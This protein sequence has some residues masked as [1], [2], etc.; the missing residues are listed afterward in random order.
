MLLLK[1]VPL[2]KKIKW[3]CMLYGMHLH[4]IT[5]SRGLP[6]FTAG[7][8]HDGDD[9]GFNVAEILRHIRPTVS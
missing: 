1:E 6:C 8:T 4:C 3:I 2:I 9:M 5:P 7:I